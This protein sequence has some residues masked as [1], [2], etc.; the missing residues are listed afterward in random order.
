MKFSHCTAITGLTQLRRKPKQR[1]PDHSSKDL[2]V[3]WRSN[4]PHGSVY[5]QIP[6]RKLNTNGCILLDA[7]IR[8][9]ANIINNSPQI[10]STFSRWKAYFYFSRKTNNTVSSMS[11]KIKVLGLHFFKICLLRKSVSF[12]IEKI[13]RKVNKCSRIHYLM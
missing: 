11:K 7:H 9:S 8:G 1:R 6:R 10:R 13:Q 3:W 5:F 4:F 12:Y 2:Q